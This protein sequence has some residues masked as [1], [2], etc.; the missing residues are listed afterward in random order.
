[1]KAVIL[2]AGDGNRLK[3]LTDTTPK[4]LLEINGKPILSYLLYILP[5]VIDEVYIIIKERHFDLFT[6]FIKNINIKA[7]INILFQDEKEKGTYF[8]L[9]SAKEFLKNEKNFLILNGDDLFNAQDIR[10]IIKI[11]APVYGLS[12]KTSDKRYKTCDL[13]ENN[14][15]IISFRN[16]KPEEEGKEVPCF[17]GLY[18]LNNDFLKYSPVYVGIEAGIP[19]TLMENNK[20][21]SYLILKNWIQINTIDEY[22]RAKDK[23]IDFIKDFC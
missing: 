1:M 15:K 6:D 18:F 20:S 10:D 7:K 22:N 9:M 19:H 14:R 13:D 4:P 11:E 23:D 5:D 2:C 21:V 17:T 3:P 8:A 16:Q 12:Y